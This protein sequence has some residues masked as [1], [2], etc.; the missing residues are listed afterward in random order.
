ME[1]DL[2]LRKQITQL[3]QL[4]ETRTAALTEA[5]TQ[6][7]K[8][9]LERKRVEARQERFL[10]AKPAQAQRQA[11][12][13]RL[14][15]ELAAALD[16]SE[17]SWCVVRGLRETLDYSN[18]AL[19][20]LDETT[21]DRIVA[22]HVGFEEHLYILESEM[23][24]RIK[25]GEG[26][27]ELPLLD[28]QLHY[29]PDVK[30]NPRYYLG[31]GG[32]EVDVP[33]QI[34][35][36]V[37]GV[38]SAESREVDAFS[39]DDFEVLT[40]AA[41]QTGLAIEKARLLAAERKR[42]DE[43]DALRTTMAEITTELELSSLLQ[44]IVKRA[45]GL[46]NA[47]GGEL[48]LYEEANQE[49]RI[50]ISHNVGEGYVGTRHAHGE[51]VMG[52]VAETREPLIIE[53]YHTWESRAPQYADVKMHASL[54]APLIVG[55]RLVGAITIATTDPA[56]QFCSADLHLLNLF[57]QQAA[58]AIENA[59]LFGETEQRA[60]EMAMLT[61][62]GKALSSTLRVDEV[63]QLIYEQTRRVM[64][65]ENM[66]IV[67]Y[68]EANHELECTFS[69]NSEDI[70]VGA[71]TTGDTGLGGYIVKHNKSL[72]LSN[73]VMERARELGIE[74]IGIPAESWLGVPMRRGERVLGVI[75]V[76]HYTTSNVYHEA[77]QVLLETIA[78]QAAIAIE[79][80]RLYD[81]AQR[82]ITERARAEAELRKY[83]EH[84]KELVEERTADLQ[85]S[86]ERYRTLFDGVPVGLYRTTPGGQMVDVNLAL[87]EM[88]G[89]PGRKD[90]LAINTASSYI[91]PEE[92]ARWKMLM[93]R[94]GVI[95]DFEVRHHRHDGTL[96]WV[97][98]TARAVKDEQGEVQYYEGSLED[99]TE[100]K[101]AEEELRK[102]QEHLEDLVE[103]R[104][105]ELQESEK[106]YRTLFNGV[107]VGLYR[108]TP[109]G[110][111]LDV[112]QAFVQMEGY[113]DRETMLT[114]NS[115]KLYVDPDEQVRWRTLMEREGV[116]RDF[117]VR[118]CQ[119]DGTVI[120]VKDTARAV[121]DEQGEVQYYEGSLEDITERKLAE[122]E[123]R[124]Y[125]EHL[126]ERVEERTAELQESEERYRTLFDGVPVGLYRTTPAGQI[127][128]A[129]LA[130]V[131][132]L[133]YP[134]REDLQVISSASFYVDPE[135]RARWQ[136][137]MEQE[138]V[139]RDFEVRNRR[140]D[141]TVIWVKE[142]A[143][144]V[145]NKQGQ[146]LYYEGSLEDITER[147]R[148]E[149]ELR[150]HREHLEELVKERTAELSESEERYRTLFDGVPVGL[151]RS[152]PSGQFLDVNQAFVQM[153]GYPDRE[154]MLK[155][156]TSKFYVDPEEQ[157]R[158]RVLMDREGIVRDFEVQHRR[159][160]GAVRWVSEAARVVKDEQGKVLYYEGS[161]EDI[162][163][164]K[165]FEE[166][167]R[168]QK[169]YFEALFVNIPVA[170]LT[171]DNNARVVSWNPMAERLFGYTQNEAI[172]QHVD[173]LVA[174]DSRVREEAQGYTKLVLAQ[175]PVVAVTKRT[176]KNGSFVDVEVRGL[177]VIVA[178][179]F[180]GY[181]A[182]YHDVSELQDARRTA[183]AANQAKSIFLA[184]MSHELR[185]PLNA[186][187]GFTQLMDSD[188]NLT[189]E[190]QTNLG[191]INRSGE[192]LLALINDV[193][194][195]S[196]IEAGR[197]TLQENCFDLYGLLDILEEMFRLRTDDKS[198][199]L[200]FARTE[201]V[202]QFVQTDEGKLR[203]V[204]TNLLGNAVKFTEEGGVALRI[205]K[206][207]EDECLIFEIEDTGPGIA[208]DELET[209]FEPFVQ[210]AN[211][212]Q[213]Q[214]GTGLG[215]SI[216]RQFAR[217]LGGDISVSSEFGQGSVF[218]FELPI[219][220]ADAAEV[221]VAQPS[222][223]VAGMEQGQPTYRLLI[224]DDRETTR[225]LLVKLLEPLGFEVREAVHG[226]EA[227]EIWERWEPHL[228][229]MDMRMPV[230]DGYEATRR[231]KAVAK[232]K[233]TVIVALTA[234]AFDE[235]QE[236]ILSAGCDDIVRKPFRQ[237]EIFDRLA[238]HLGVCFIYEEESIQPNSALTAETSDVL[239]PAALAAL[240]PDWV[241]ELQQATTKANLN[242]ILDLIDQIRGQNGALA[243]ALADLAQNFD[244]KKILALIEQAE[245]SNGQ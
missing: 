194:E 171:A 99:I 85:K 46:L 219:G 80:A 65:G 128:D 3:E 134:S 191:I 61:E 13:L 79:N 145:K 136:A 169:E 241:T 240:P 78:S 118:N 236:T 30:Q 177:P 138:G 49:V 216:S 199:T 55:S 34:G 239:T 209:V 125:Q 110:Q 178:G 124:K 103:E 214:E 218:R 18:V 140:Q 129:N 158:W 210:T 91:D 120:W 212:E 245:G 115:S 45:T 17:V 164:R 84:L 135:D 86:E 113:P 231:I 29:T 117:E 148:A 184:N 139:V 48:G 141:G 207:I 100:R 242:Q 92:R 81:Q 40:A 217:L 7:E 166:E 235:D 73:N 76:Q 238:K 42:A 160:D 35:G 172:S 88:L 93:E 137:L 193:L 16:E 14:S 101:L 11:A 104:T 43:L 56:R 6:L 123:L 190:Q 130:F 244:Y 127:V 5:Q 142:T 165:R 224:V 192:H 39:Q 143:R 82:E 9:I 126:E 133:G 185:T 10:E 83:Q 75:V 176:R 215:L 22:A 168:R 72:L 161:I 122:E 181:I 211:I 228:I 21:G 167:L 70:P 15:A 183:E 20:I 57:A 186:I 201:E 8:A 198:L 25:P 227:I 105:A 59:R 202:P 1:K 203:Q 144:A 38:L 27:S 154:T 77:H 159:Y 121:K 63:L 119:Q 60:T 107:P 96:I 187:L 221:K 152:T 234:S 225:Q 2:E 24:V 222:R 208:P 200:S 108:S 102:Y 50:V 44:A 12:L 53:D 155:V 69:T 87:V 179:E 226:Q 51:G 116:V 41:Q 94:E 175:E 28:G 109:S 170:A 74:P 151:Y 89:Y 173:D 153:E 4:V 188:P 182:I 52:H 229:W 146:V 150:K 213:S 26:L 196:K 174:T 230:M 195:M 64:Y 95:R 132:M 90:L 205:S 233:D 23:P 204:L 33:V 197:V 237:E 54:A 131:E 32:S 106:R 156:N 243:D 147:K 37:L 31:A 220:V 232:G 36:K 114:V 66:L 47:T 19:T 206:A 58:I 162:T 223:R 97:K 180:A 71:R 62:V 189:T 163:D 67:F 112:N 157:I 149:E 98:D 68:D 111:F